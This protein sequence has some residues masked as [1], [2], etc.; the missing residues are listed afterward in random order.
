MTYFAK[1]FRLKK[2]EMGERTVA[3]FQKNEVQRRDESLNELW[4]DT[5][6]E[7]IK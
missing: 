6:T 5:K 3:V 4:L 7:V 2:G 1:S